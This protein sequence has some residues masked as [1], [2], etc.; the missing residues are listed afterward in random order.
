MLFEY[1]ITE[2]DELGIHPVN[3][4]MCRARYCTH[5]LVDQLW[6]RI[7]DGLERCPGQR[8]YVR[9]TKRPETHRVRRTIDETQL[10]GKLAVSQHSEAGKVVTTGAFYDL[11]F[12]NQDDVQGIIAGSIPDEK[13]TVDQLALGHK[14]SQDLDF[15]VCQLGTEGR[16][17]YQSRNI[18]H[19][20]NYPLRKIQG[21]LGL[22][23]L[24]KYR[25]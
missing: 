14:G 5:D 1:V 3:D 2:F 12:S 20:T 22:P 15:R 8:Q 18:V 25:D 10:T 17:D 4:P 23:T 6:V 19:G 13:V 7:N 21:Q 9:L 11:D 24:L 16:V